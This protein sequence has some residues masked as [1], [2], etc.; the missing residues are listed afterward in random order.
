MK[1]IP[2]TMVDGLTS[3]LAGMGGAVSD[4]ANDSLADMPTARLKGR[5]TAGDG[6]PEDLTAAQATGILNA[7]TTGAK[8]LAP[9]SGGAVLGRSYKSLATF[10]CVAS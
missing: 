6:S 8:G 2:M 5:V 3:T 9:A 1:R 4:I 10:C 7:F